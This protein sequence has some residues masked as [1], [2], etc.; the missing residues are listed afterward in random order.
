MA[1]KLSHSLPP[2][3]GEVEVKVYHSGGWL[4]KTPN[5]IIYNDA[6]VSPYIY[7]QLRICVRRVINFTIRPQS[8]CIGR[9]IHNGLYYVPKYIDKCKP[10]LFLLSIHRY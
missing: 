10:I 1:T 5:T 4:N 9:S 3:G 7:G 6:M 2:E 8:V